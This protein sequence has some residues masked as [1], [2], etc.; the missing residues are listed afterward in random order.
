MRS[1]VSGTIVA[2]LRLSSSAL[3]Y[4]NGL[5]DDPGCRIDSVAR[6]NGASV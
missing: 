6:L 2:A 4:T 1:A 5:N 3:A